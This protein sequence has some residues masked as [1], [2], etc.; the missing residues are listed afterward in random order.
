MRLARTMALGATAAL[1]LAS[2]A[3][4]F[5]SAP[6]GVTFLA[7]KPAP[8]QQ[9]D[10]DASRTVISGDGRF[11]VYHHKSE[12][13]IVA[14]KPVASCPNPAATSSQVYRT[15]LTHG[16]D[17]ARQQGDGRVLRER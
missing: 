7:G 12:N 16:R 14:N 1:A 8:G 11:V 5:T 10:N 17:V 2:T 3:S 15:D 13:L 6:D 9:Y 4:G